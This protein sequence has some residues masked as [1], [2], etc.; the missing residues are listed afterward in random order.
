MIYSSN[1]QRQ[2]FQLPWIY[3][4]GELETILGFDLVQTDMAS[5]GNEVESRMITK[6]IEDVVVYNHHNGQHLQCK[7][8]LW[9]CM[10]SDNKPMPR[11]FIVLSSNVEDNDF[12]NKKYESNGRYL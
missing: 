10:M 8:Y 12:A 11:G 9:S 6:R 5:L 4:H 1:W 2:W 3:A 7:M